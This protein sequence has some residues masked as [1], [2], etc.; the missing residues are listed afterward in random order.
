LS[1]SAIAQATKEIK[2]LTVVV[3]ICD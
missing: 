2:L 3:S 1:P